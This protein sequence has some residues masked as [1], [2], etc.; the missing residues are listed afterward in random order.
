MDNSHIAQARAHFGLRIRQLRQQQGLT[1]IALAA[2][3]GVT[4]P[5]IVAVE[6]GHRAVGES[7]AGRLASALSVCGESLEEFMFASVAT[8]KV[9]RFRQ[10]VLH[11]P[12]EIT[13]FAP[14]RLESEGLGNREIERAELNRNPAL[15]SSPLRLEDI[16]LVVGHWERELRTI[17]EALCSGDPAAHPLLQVWL[18]NGG[19]RWAVILVADYSC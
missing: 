4:E 5:A 19:R 9:G 14:K 18:R 11:L 10:S 13:H 1:L 16:R 3:T 17:R 7:L 2:R 12:P 8:R 15:F 6:Q